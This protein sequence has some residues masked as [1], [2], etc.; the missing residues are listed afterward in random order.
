MAKGTYFDRLR[1]A[2]RPTRPDA[3]P[4]AE[5]VGAS[6]LEKLRERRGEAAPTDA[7]T[8]TPTDPTTPMCPTCGG[9]TTDGVC[10]ECDTSETTNQAGADPA[11]D[12]DERQTKAGEVS[13]AAEKDSATMADKNTTSPSPS[14]PK[15]AAPAGTTTEA[16]AAPKAAS[17]ADLRQ[18]FPDDNEFVLEAAEK[19]WSVM[20]A[21]SQKL[22]RMMADGSARNAVNTA[23]GGAG[24]SKNAG[25]AG[26]REAA[27]GMGGGLIPPSAAAAALQDP[28]TGNYGPI[29]G[30][31]TY[32][33]AVSGYMLAGM[34]L[35]DAHRWAQHNHDEL[36]TAKKQTMGEQLAKARE[37]NERRR[38]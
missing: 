37:A 10:A 36:W 5:P 17:I 27:G 33:E 1:L 32:D 29:A 8:D 19:G 23:L 16:P 15:N 13:P 25:G 28:V 31:K 18:A 14:D 4:L 30:A 22:D 38:Q 34:R 35:K 9:P 21:K 12:P 24:V 26:P 7:P 20:E 11:V 6:R 2:L 3:A